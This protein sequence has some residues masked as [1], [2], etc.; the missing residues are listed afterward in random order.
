MKGQLQA[1]E[2]NDW[3]FARV[4]VAGTW[5][6]SDKKG[7]P[8]A[9]EVGDI[10]EFENFT[11]PGKDGKTYNNFK[12]GSF[13][14]VSGAPAGKPVDTGPTA[15]KDEY[16]AKKEANDAA[17]EPRIIYFAAF[18]RAVQF[19]KLAFTAGAL[20]AVTKV[21]KD[22]DKFDVLAK[23]VDD[24]AQRLIANAYGQAATASPAAPA[25]EA[26]D[27]SAQPEETADDGDKW[28]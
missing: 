8:P 26:V 19:I 11:K 22:A 9:C 18:E 4:K 13:A 7:S 10:I 15:S 5:Y 14:R 25:A 16:W 27:E 23:L 20:D 2:M 24:T 3:G 28:A 6:G 21:K 1:K 17:K 12:F